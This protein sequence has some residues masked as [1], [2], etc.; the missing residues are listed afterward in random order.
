MVTLTTE[1]TIYNSHLMQSNV[2]R[3]QWKAWRPFPRASNG[4][5]GMKES[6]LG[7]RFAY[8][9]KQFLIGAAPQ[10]QIGEFHGGLPLPVVRRVHSCGY[11]Y[12]LVGCDGF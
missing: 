3:S 2:T 9:L 12:S 8:L 6:L 5:I 1:M 11:R 7:D 4:N 10:Q